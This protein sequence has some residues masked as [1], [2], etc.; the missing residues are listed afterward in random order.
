MEEKDF[1]EV[2]GRLYLEMYRFKEFSAMMQKMAADRDRKIKELE[3]ELANAL[4]SGK[5]AAQD[6]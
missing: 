5:K 6:T 3:K 1:F 4:A 2:M